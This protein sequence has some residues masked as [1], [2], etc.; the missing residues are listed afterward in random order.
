MRMSRVAGFACGA[1]SLVGCYS[2]QPTRGATPTVGETVAFDVNDS[3]RAALGGSMG[4]EIGQIEGVRLGESD[5]VFCL[6]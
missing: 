2:L 4:P 1:L 6:L 5:A 3:G